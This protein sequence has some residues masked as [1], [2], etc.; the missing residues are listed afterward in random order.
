[1]ATVFLRLFAPASALFQVK[2]DRIH[3]ILYLKRGLL[4]NILLALLEIAYCAKF[5]T[6]IVFNA[7]LSFNLQA[8]FQPKIN[9]AEKGSENLEL[10]NNFISFL[11]VLTPQDDF[12]QFKDIYGLRVLLT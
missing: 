2:H 4:R 8:L 10:E 6:L 12:V 1:M 7:N 9:V 5:L 3:Y 11:N